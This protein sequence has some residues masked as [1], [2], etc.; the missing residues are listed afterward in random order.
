MR[1][2]NLELKDAP[3]MLEWMH[4]ESVVGK[5][6]GNFIE[7]TLADAREKGL[8]D[9]AKERSE[10]D[11]LYTVS[12]DTTRS[13]VERNAATDKL[14]KLYPSYFS[15]LSNEEILAGK[16]AS[17]YDKLSNS[18]VANAEARAIQNKITEIGDIPSYDI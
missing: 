8:K 2:R 15:N 17:A 6:K 9:S 11:L 4:D 5:L 1:L 16:A 3:L 14:Q 18:L 13:M 12:Q 7:K 10:L